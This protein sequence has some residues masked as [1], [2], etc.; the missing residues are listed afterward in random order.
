MA[1]PPR[2]YR[3]TPSPQRNLEI[4]ERVVQAVNAREVPEDV[5][6]PGFQMVNRASAVTDYTYHGATG[7]RDW[8]DDIFEEF[9]SGAR[10]E[11]EEVV[12]EAWD[13]VVATFRIS[14][15]S[16]R[17]RQP[18]EFRWTSVTWF[19]AGR[20]TRTAGYATP[21]EALEAAG[22]SLTG[23]RLLAHGF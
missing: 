12:A 10:Y 21:D 3:D 13:R 14:G 5:L 2:P 18:L 9:L 20:A 22:I 6:A 19:D 1:S 11:M 23:E 15:R 17:S 8:M 16:A 7:W 4:H